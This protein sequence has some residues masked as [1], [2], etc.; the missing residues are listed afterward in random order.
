MVR[1][2]GF[3]LQSFWQK[4]ENEFFLVQYL[5]G[6]R[7]GTLVRY[8]LI[9]KFILGTPSLPF[10]QHVKKGFKIFLVAKYGKYSALNFIKQKCF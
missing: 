6:Y 1:A 8:G 10:L 3:G 2:Q 9:S 4:P 7:T 5:P